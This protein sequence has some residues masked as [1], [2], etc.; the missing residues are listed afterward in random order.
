MADL[1]EVKIESGGFPG[2]PGWTNLYFACSDD[3]AR[4]GALALAFDWLG[5]IAAAFPTG[6]SC[7]IQ[8]E[9]RVMPDDTGILEDY[10]TTPDEYAVNVPGTY[11]TGGFGSGVSG[12]CVAWGTSTVSGHRRIRGRTF[13]VPIARDM[14]AS[15][16]TL[17]DGFVADLKTWSEAMTGASGF[18]LGVWHRPVHDAGGLFGAVTSV[19]V[20]PHAAYLR[21]RRT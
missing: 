2:G 16:G 17:S 19:E 11:P 21:T 12:A 20:Q 1:L 15:D 5:L 3:A 14:Y 4:E 6:W 7:H 10:Y 13:L 9:L 8:P 18:P